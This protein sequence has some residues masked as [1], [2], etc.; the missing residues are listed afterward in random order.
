MTYK[1]NLSNLSLNELESNYMAKTKFEYNKLERS[2]INEE[3]I[4]LYSKINKPMFCEQTVLANNK[5]LLTLSKFIDYKINNSKQTYRAKS[6]L[7]LIDQIAKSL[8]SELIKTGECKI[9]LKF[10]QYGLQ[11]N[12]RQKE[13]KIF[14][15]LLAKHIIEEIIKIEKE[16]REVSKTIQ[17]SK[18]AKHLHF[19][20]KKLLNSANI[21]G[22]LKFNNNSYKLLSKTTFNKNKLLKNFFS[23]LF[24]AEHRLK[25]S[26]TY[27]KVLFS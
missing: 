2:T 16:L 19:Y 23:E 26:I 17:K 13:I 14:K 5:Y 18:N 25:V 4:I 6:N 22:V 11:F 8:S 21:Y 10:K 24:E 27:L 20:R 1:N 12:L 9:F 15:I 7:I 3:L